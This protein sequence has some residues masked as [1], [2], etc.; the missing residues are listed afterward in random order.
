MIPTRTI[1]EIQAEFNDVL[2]KYASDSSLMKILKTS[3]DGVP[4]LHKLFSM[5]SAT[6]RKA[7]EENI[8]NKLPNHF[9]DNA[10]IVKQI[11]ND[12]PQTIEM[13]WYDM[14]EIKCGSITF[15]PEH[16]SHQHIIDTHF[17]KL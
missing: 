8:G 1:E 13:W 11:E 15:K 2:Q 3:R 4:N 12:E 5:D 17:L 6:L 16:G 14:V 9:L 7:L 10:K